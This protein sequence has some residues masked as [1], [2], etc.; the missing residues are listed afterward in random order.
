[1]E[2]ETGVWDDFGQ[3]VD[4]T[5]RLREIL[6]NYPEGTSILKELVQNAVRSLLLPPR[7]AVPPAYSAPRPP[8]SAQDD[9]GAKTVRVCLD[10]RTHGVDTLAY[11]KLAGFQ[12]PSLLVFNDSVFRESDFESISRI[13]DSVK[14]EQVGKTGRFGVGFNSVYHLTDM[15]S[16]VSGRHVVFFDPHCAFL[17]NVNAANPGKRI[18]FVAND[19]LGAN[20]D[21]FA[22][23]AAFGCDVRNEFRGTTF[24]FPLRTP[25]QA[26]SSKLSKTSYVPDGVRRLL[27]AFAREKTLDMLF[28]K[29]AETVEVL[30]WAPGETSPR[31]IS[32]TS[33]RDP[34]PTLRAA[35]GAFTRASAAMAAGTPVEPHGE[36]EVTFETEG[37]DEDEDDDARS[38]TRPTPRARTFLVS[39]ALGEN[40]A[41][42]VTANREKYGMKLVPWAAVAAELAPKNASDGDAEKTS[43]ER[44]DDAGRAFCFL[45]LPARTGLPV[46]VNAY[47]E[48]SSNRRDIWFGED[49]A[50]GG[51]AR[52]EWNRALLELAAAPRDARLIVAAKARLG[53]SR[54]YYALLPRVTLPRRGARWWRER[55]PSSATRPCFTP[56]RTA[57]DGSPRGGDVPRSRDDVRPVVGRGARRRGRLHSGRAGGG[58]RTNGRT[59]GVVS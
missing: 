37:E 12:G 27:R 13:G 21:Q 33:V 35:R 49:M 40:L 51:A 36:Y 43:R 22:P 26:A 32:R 17:P 19:V 44:R 39:Q 58:A 31:L 47:F 56:P 29:N 14:R 6:L 24:R 30:E 5:A 59:R 8:L 34:T 52:S 4:L 18:D 15:P 10:E 53:P 11:D 45:P 57:G 41:P 54:D 23:F 7:G 48:L 3:K 28:L 25:A 38:G 55:A 16:F 50:G 42:L 20:P 2:T 1:M 46:H 9:A